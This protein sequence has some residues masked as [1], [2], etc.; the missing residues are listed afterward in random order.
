MLC[1][2]INSIRDM[3][4]FKNKHIFSSFEA[5]NFVSDPSLE[6]IRNNEYT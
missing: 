6:G 4:M 3:S 2:L 1:P 5:S